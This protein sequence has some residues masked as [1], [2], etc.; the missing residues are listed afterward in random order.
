MNCTDPVLFGASRR[1][2]IVAVEHVEKAS[3]PDEMHLFVREGESLACDVVPFLPFLVVASCALADCTGQ[4][5]TRSLAGPGPLNHLAVFD[6]WKECV[7]ARK[8]LSKM[9]AVPAS[10]ATAPY[11]MISDPVQQY[12]MTSGETLFI[13]MEFDELNRMQVDIEC[14]TSEG[15]D[16][17]NAQ[18]E[19]DAIVA[20]AMGDQTGW[21]KVLRGDE[22]DEATLLQEFV[23]TVRERDPDVIEGHNIFN[24]DLPYIEVR[25]KRHGVGLALGRDGSLPTSRPSR[26]SAAERSIAYRRYRIFGRHVVDTLFLLQ[27]YDVSHRSLPSYGLKDAAI[28]FGFVSPKRTYIDGG[29]ISNVYHSDPARVMAYVVD[30]IEETRQLSTHLSGS[31]FM[32]TRMLPLSY[33]TTC[34]KGQALKIDALMVRAYLAE[35]QA[36]PL[37]DAEQEFAGGYTDMFIEGVVENVHHC[38]IRS[39][40]PSLMLTQGIAPQSDSLGHFLAMLDSLRA[41]RLSAKE[42]MKSAASARERS[43]LDALQ[44]TFKILINSFYGYLGFRQGRFSD[45]DAAAKVA[46]EGRDLL[47]RMIEEL[48]K[49]GAQPIEID[50]DGIYFVPPSFGGSADDNAARMEE[51]RQRFSA[52]LP[53]GIDVEFD[54]EYTSMYSYKMKNYALLCNDGELI[55]KGAALKSRGLE[56]FQRGF[57]EELLRNKLERHDE[58]IPALKLRLEEQIVNRELPIEQLAKTESLQDSPAV[59]QSKR[60]SGKG[61]RRAAYELALGSS[62]EYRA[63][64]QVSFYVTG[65]AKSVAVH[66]NSKLVSEWNPD[67]R[68]EN[69]AYYVAKLDTLYK[70][71]EGEHAD[72]RQGELF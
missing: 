49:D 23:N 37:P 28:H 59:Y 60:E 16:F 58:R 47:R 44:S 39:L 52:S 27:S 65:T 69:I 11:F 40:Y 25:A 56:P 43:S 5:E 57:L 36:L 63:G 53:E 41:F 14:L 7:N 31:S 4:L 19:G 33:Q 67:Q 24:F 21:T 64:D 29:Q 48:E 20:I 13:G 51:F 42:G 10:S 45:F 71:F 38:D 55:I 17:C 54:G 68:D 6:R 15:Y 46:G 61:S 35:G 12:L 1:E 2:R 62:R 18:R 22:M 3:S 26:F 9:T 72:A 50:T 34:V 8:R 70:K 30:D 66:A 32:Q